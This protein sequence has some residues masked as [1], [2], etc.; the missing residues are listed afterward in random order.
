M[1]PQPAFLNDLHM[2]DGSR[3]HKVV[4]GVRFHARTPH[5]DI[6][7]IINNDPAVFRDL[8]RARSLD[9]GMKNAWFL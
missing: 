3:K 4:V 6:V 5:T 7:M 2:V 1:G 8:R 9:Q